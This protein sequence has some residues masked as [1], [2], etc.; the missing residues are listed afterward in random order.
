[1]MVKCA[2]E[3]FRELACKYRAAETELQQKD[4]DI[5]CLKKLL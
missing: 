5:E 4:F 3:K 2:V 1:M